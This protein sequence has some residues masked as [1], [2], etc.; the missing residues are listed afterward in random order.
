MGLIVLWK[1]LKNLFTNHPRQQD[2]T[3]LEHAKFALSVAG[4]CFVFSVFLFIHALFPFFTAPK[5]FDLYSTRKYLT[6][7]VLP[8]RNTVKCLGK[9]KSVTGTKVN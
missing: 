2:E 9:S 4:R 8:E 7:S 5:A 3:Y 6:T 1:Q